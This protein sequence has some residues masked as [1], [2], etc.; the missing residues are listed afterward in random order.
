MNSLPVQSSSEAI[1]VVTKFAT[2]V[3][4]VLSDADFCNTF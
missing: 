3:S 2:A 4:K 1:I